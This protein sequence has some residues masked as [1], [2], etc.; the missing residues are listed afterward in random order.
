MIPTR[1]P[2]L[3]R[4]PVVLRAFEDRDVPAVAAASRDPLIPLV[5]TVPTTDDPAALLAY[6]ERQHSRLATGAGYSFAVA[7]ATTDEAVGQIGLWTADIAAGRATVGY[8]ISPDRR[9]R[10]YASAAL[11]AVT[12]WAFTLEEVARVQLHVEPWNEGSWRAAEACG[13]QREGVLRSWQVVGTERRDMAV[14]S[15]LRTDTRPG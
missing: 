10:G 9:R 7:D 13:Y 11:A 12:A 4:P 15:V 14:Y 6:V 2:R 1:L 3:H 8:W 5:T